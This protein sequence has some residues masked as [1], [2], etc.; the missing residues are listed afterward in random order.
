MLEI[1]DLK[2]FDSN[3]KIVKAFFDRILCVTLSLHTAVLYQDL[4]GVQHFLD[5]ENIDLNERDKVGRTALHLAVSTQNKAKCETLEKI[6]MMLLDHGADPNIE[7]SLFKWRP[8][9]FAEKARLWFAV[10]ILIEKGADKSDL[11][12]VKDNFDDCEYV[13]D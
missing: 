1:L 5:L 11:D 12:A 4:P 3:W 7:D 9:R 13:S 2:L 10:E 6:L 8:L